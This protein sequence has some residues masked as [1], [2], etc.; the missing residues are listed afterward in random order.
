MHAVLKHW[1]PMIGRDMHIPWPPGSPAPAPAPVP[2]FTSFLMLG[3]GFMSSYAK[4]HFSQGIGMTMQM[5]TDIGMMIPHIGAPS[6]LLP[7][8]IPLSS[9]KSYFGPANHQAEGKPIAAALL[10]QV[11]PNLNCGTP[12]PLPLGTVIALNTHYVGMTLADVMGGLGAMLSDFVIQAALQVVGGRVTGAV[13]GRLGGAIAS[14]LSAR[15]YQRALF[16]A[17]MRGDKWAHMNA[18]M[19]QLGFERWVNARTVSTA[20]ENTIGFF[21]G[22]PMGLDAG[23]FGGPTAAG[24]PSDDSQSWARGQGEALG[25]AIDNYL[26]SPSVEDYGD[27]PEPSGDSATA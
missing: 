3:L 7:I 22:G 14:R 18:V 8:E 25:N 12:V 27:Y 11:N 2:Y 15:V 17:L 5:G 10:V 19:R 4:T 6:T 26:S 13:S 9:S 20:I 16:R 24:G 21:V 1:H 23:T